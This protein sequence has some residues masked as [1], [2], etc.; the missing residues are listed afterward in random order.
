MVFNL[1]TAYIELT[2]ANDELKKAN[3]LK[4]EFLANTSHELKTPLTGIIGIAE[5]LI[6]GAAGNLTEA[7][8]SNLQMVVLS[9]RRLAHLV[10][11][12]LD[13]SRMKNNDIVLHCKPIDIRQVTEIVIALITPMIGH[14]A[15]KIINRINP[16]MP[17]VYADENRIQQILYNLTGN[18]VKFTDSGT[19]TLQIL[20]AGRLLRHKKL[21]RNR[22]W[23]CYYKKPGGTSRW[24]NK[25]NLKDR[26]GLSIQV[27]APTE[28]REVCRKRNSSPQILL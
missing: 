12:I 9:G 8:K 17:E 11:D 5:S 3:L 4:D 28:R 14:K 7:Q 21:R 19:I 15:L 2:A 20:Q 1:K 27:H 24:N 13:F 18:A 10:N 16:D 25:R 22:S 6:D 26:F 23:T